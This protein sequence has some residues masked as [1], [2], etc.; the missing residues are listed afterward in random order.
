VFKHFAIFLI[1]ISIILSCGY[2][3]VSGKESLQ[4]TEDM[5]KRDQAWGDMIQAFELYLAFFEDSYPAGNF[6]ISHHAD[7]QEEALAYFSQA[8]DEEL[9][10]A[11]TNA[12]TFY[13]PDNNKLQIL[14]TDGIPVLVSE[15][16]NKVSTQFIDADHVMFQRCFEDYYGENTE[17][18]YQVFCQYDGGKWKI[19]KLEWNPV[20]RAVS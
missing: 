4:G 17:Y 5:K 3:Y 13:N 11:I 2:S 9:A 18:I 16:P 7:T 19:Y 6:T 1:I 8:F 15:N 10:A 20:D 14:P 12:Y